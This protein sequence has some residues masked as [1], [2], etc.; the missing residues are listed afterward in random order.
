MSITLQSQV[1]QALGEFN[2]AAGDYNQATPLLQEAITLGWRSNNLVSATV[3]A[4]RLGVM[5][6]AQGHLL[7]AEQLY[8]DNLKML[9]D[10]GLRDSSL[11]GRA[12]IGLGDIL[13]EKGDLSE[14]EKTLAK[15]TEHSRLQS[16]PYDLVFAYLYSSRLDLE[17]GDL[18]RA[19]AWLHQ[20][21]ELFSSY[22]IPLSISWMRDYYAVPVWIAN[23]DWDCIASWIRE[24]DLRVEDS[25][26]FPNELP[27][28]A[29]AR[30]LLARGQRSQALQVLAN[31]SQQVEAA[32]RYGRLIEVS[33]L[34]AIAEFEEGDV[35]AA[36]SSLV[37]SLSLAKRE[38]YVRIFL[39]EG[40]AM[41]D[42]LTHLLESDAP[43]DLVEYAYQLLTGAPLSSIPSA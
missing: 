6:K 29:F 31:L 43:P 14:A 3:S 10:M 41:L 7:A 38:G 34:Q 5:F 12:E 1:C 42:L 9:S 22:S 16:Q 26:S 33:N 39:D 36:L 2:M 27:R 23:E 4:F 13:R 25:A 35:E 32:G 40:K 28:M 11:R 30:V 20:A 21:D 18:K 37:R 17:K 15:G 8:L 19:R 24:R